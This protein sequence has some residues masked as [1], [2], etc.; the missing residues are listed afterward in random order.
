MKNEFL[1]FDG[2]DGEGNSML[3]FSGDVEDISLES[4]EEFD[5]IFRSKAKKDCISRQ[6]ALGKS[7]SDARKICRLEKRGD[8]AGT[9]AD[10]PSD[11]KSCKQFY[12]DKGMSKRS[13]SIKCKISTAGQVVSDL[14]DAIGGGSGEEELTTENGMPTNQEQKLAGLGGKKALM[15]AGGVLV[16]GLIGFLA[17]RPRR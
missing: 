2:W 5:Y 9:S 7:N 12:M 14:G 3:D 6:K 11:K 4:D 10:A 15:I 16:L 13:A 1:N 17:L 8:D